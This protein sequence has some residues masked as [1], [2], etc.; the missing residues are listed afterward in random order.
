MG[1]S[2]DTASKQANE[3][4]QERG[5]KLEAIIQSKLKQ[6]ESTIKDGAGAFEG[7]KA[8]IFQIKQYQAYY[9]YDVAKKTASSIK[10]ATDKLFESDWSAAV[11]GAAQAVL[12]GFLGGA[13]QGET[14]YR[15]YFVYF[16]NFS[17]L[18]V[19]IFLYKIQATRSGGANEALSNAVASMIVE[20]YVDVVKIAPEAIAALLSEAHRKSLFFVQQNIDAI[21]EAQRAIYRSFKKED[22]IAILE[23]Y[24]EF[25]VDPTSI[26][27]ETQIRE[28]QERFEHFAGNLDTKL[29]KD[30]ES[31]KAED[32]LKVIEIWKN[33]Y[34]T[35]FKFQEALGK[36]KKELGESKPQLVEKS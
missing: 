13:S 6:F 8:P 31:L 12:D 36:A 5:K 35:V 26:E 23:Q 4:V 19:D 9:S 16:E 15:D 1:S 17:L 32:P 22:V 30:L 33:E 3:E 25:M 14:T 29:R 11:K 18:R 27:G 21:R 2:L 34:E 24:P 28:I 10:T 20:S 7:D